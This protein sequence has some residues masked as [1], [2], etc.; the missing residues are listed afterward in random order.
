MTRRL[1]SE[2]PWRAVRI[3]FLFYLLN[4]MVS[5]DIFS[6]RE[7]WGLLLLVLLI[8][9]PRTVPGPDLQP[10]SAPARPVSVEAHGPRPADPQAIT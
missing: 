1:P 5:G 4:A 2:G 9:V 7:T 6:D 8:E 10:V 3:L